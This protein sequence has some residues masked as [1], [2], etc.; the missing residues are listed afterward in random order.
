LQSSNSGNNKYT[1]KRPWV[2]STIIMVAAS[3]GGAFG[4]NAIWLNPAIDTSG[5]ASG[6]TKTQTVKGDAIQYRYGTVELEVTA[7]AGKIEKITELQASTSSGW[8]SA[9]PVLNQEAIKAQSANFGNLSGATFIT[10]AYKQALSNA[11]SKL[12]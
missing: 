6:A 9:I 3:V 2:V 12:K 1:K 4:I 10:D 8:E 5:S 11:L 7:T